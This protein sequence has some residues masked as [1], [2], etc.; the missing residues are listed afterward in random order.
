VTDIT[1]VVPGVV[2][3]VGPA[4]IGKST[5]AARHFRPDEILSSDELR[6][7]IRGDPTDQSVSRVAFR[8]LHREL[9][10]RLADGRL[11]VVDATNLTRASRLALLRAARPADVRVT[12]VVLTAP[13]EV[14]HARNAG[15]GPRTVP[16]DVVDRH[17]AAAAALGETAAGIEELLRA[18]GF[19]AAHV[20]T[21]VGVADEPA[22][23][24]VRRPR[25]P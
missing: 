10:K 15:R 13:A 20:V 21:T 14:V 23:L 9:A 7:A 8:I 1:V 2:V 3:L 22:I 6:G 18:E 16:A 4:G 24:Q 25:H 11:V 5:F 19:D 17:L 12:A